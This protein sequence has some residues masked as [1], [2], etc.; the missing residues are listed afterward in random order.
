MT[1]SI[2]W[3]PLT[4]IPVP[5]RPIKITCY[6]PVIIP[7]KP[8]KITWFCSVCSCCQVLYHLSPYNAKIKGV[9]FLNSHKFSQTQM[10]STIL[11]N[12]VLGVVKCGLQNRRIPTGGLRK[13]VT[14]YSD[15]KTLYLK[16]RYLHQHIACIL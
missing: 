4:M 8:T 13:R 1:W 15:L 11:H 6:I 14:H 2:E 7:N 10:S 9:M 12:P 5:N 16:E 3:D